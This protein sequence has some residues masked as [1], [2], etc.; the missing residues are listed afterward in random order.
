MLSIS[1]FE[2][3]ENSFYAENIQRCLHITI[4]NDT[5]E[6]IIVEES[7]I[8]IFINNITQ[9]LPLSEVFG[10]VASKFLTLY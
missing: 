6:Q 10:V 3:C 7:F 1:K 9:F 5:V 4:N 2:Y 8:I